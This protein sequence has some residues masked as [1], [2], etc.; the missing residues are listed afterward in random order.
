MTTVVDTA[1]STRAESDTDEQ[2]IPDVVETIHVD[3]KT[4]MDKCDRTAGSH[5]GRY[6]FAIQPAGNVRL[7]LPKPYRVLHYTKSMIDLPG[8]DDEALLEQAL[9]LFHDNHLVSVGGLRFDS[10]NNIF[11]YWIQII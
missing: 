7:D 10:D 3:Y 6:Y 11:T 8:G 5:V 1:Q 4:A 2:R 9:Q